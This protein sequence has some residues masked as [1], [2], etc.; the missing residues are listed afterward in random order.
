MNKVGPWLIC[1]LILE[2]CVMATS[3]KLSHYKKIEGL[4]PGSVYDLGKI[5]PE[6]VIR[7]NFSWI[8]I[9][10]FGGSPIFTF[11]KVVGNKVV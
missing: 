2:I 1:L 5:T 10:N 3:S 8:L 11:Y 9:T 6:D 4:S 7:I